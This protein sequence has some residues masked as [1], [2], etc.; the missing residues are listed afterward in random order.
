M[1]FGIFRLASISQGVYRRIL[2]GNSAREGEAINGCAALAEQS[3]AILEGGNNP[4][5]YRSSWPGLSGPP[6]ITVTPEN[7][8]RR[9]SQSSRRGDHGSPG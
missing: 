4:L 1:A 8:R 3:L 7:P 9:H 6:M 2:G 5:P